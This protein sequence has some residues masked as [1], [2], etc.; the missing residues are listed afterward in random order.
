V[1]LYEQA[2]AIYEANAKS[3]YD[4]SMLGVVEGLAYQYWQSGQQQKAIALY[5]R[6]I[7]IASNAPN[8]NAQSKASTMW[9]IGL[10]YHTGGRDDLAK[11][12][13]DQSVDVFSKEIARLERDKPD[14]LALPAMYGQLGLNYQQMGN[15]PE[16]DKYLR[17][18]NAAELKSP[19]GS[20]A[21][22]A[23][24]AQ[25]VRAEGKPAEALALLQQQ[26]ASYAKRG[27]QYAHVLDT[28]IA[29]ILR[30]MGQLG[31][32]TKLLVAYRDIAAKQYGKRHLM[33]AIA[34][35]QL[36]SMYMLSGD[37]ANASKVLTESLEIS[38]RDLS[39]A[40]KI[41]TESD[42]EIYFSRYGYVLDSAVNFNATFARQL[43]I[44]AKLALE[45]VLRRKGR[46]LD[47]TASSMATIRAKLA[48]EDKQLLDDLASARSQLAKLTVAGPSATGD[49][50]YA[51]A[52]AALEDQISKL[53]IQVGQKSAQYRAV[54]QPITLA[55]VQ[56]VLPKDARLV[57]IINFQPYDA[58]TWTF[59]PNQKKLQRR[60]AAYV[61]A[62]A[63]D[64]TFVDLG[65]AQPID[66]A[67]TAF[68]K[69]VSNPKNTHV[70]D[71]GHALYALTMAKLAGAIGSSTEILIAPDGALNLVPFA[72]L[73]DDK[74]Q[75]LIERDNFTYLTS[76]RDLLRLSVRTK[77]QG[78]G[79][80]FANPAFDASGG[81]TSDGT[82]GARSA[83]LA[84]LMWPQLPGT[85]E[86]ADLV[87]HT[88][89]GFA[90]YR[91]AR[92][93]EGALKAL[94]G[95]RILHL[96]THGFFL[97]DEPPKETGPEGRAMVSPA[98]AAMIGPQPTG[99]ENPLLR[100][101]LALAGANKLKSGDDDGILT[102]LEASGLDLW[103]TQLVVLSACDTGNGK[104]TNGDGVYGLRRALVIAGAES[105]VMSLWQ[106]DD[107]AT[108]DLM[109]GYYERLKAGKPRSSALRD[110]QLAIH[111]QAKYAH[112]FY[113]A[114]FLAAGDNT[115]LN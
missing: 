38:E 91:G 52:V 37:N 102:A 21:W 50:D 76:G 92:A 28:T 26:S 74:G 105:L 89:Q 85:G 73:V 23:T 95:P 31:R 84:S 9:S 106:V 103:G 80:M 108:R 93:T 43:P 11:P 24:L 8:S 40:L 20:G 68:R 83:D 30:E 2:L 87:E 47:A 111:H 48:P 104:I 42:H 39:N 15:L 22:T 41:G 1:R 75:L 35:Q 36:A 90:D 115:P 10:I 7:E 64:P 45:T 63:G 53:E 33:Y 14:D 16:A 94:H 49:D 29:D 81:G 66:D 65:P 58:K 97:P 114:A 12:L 57:E 51:K 109:A 100:S 98:L 5:N 112:P 99:S 60:Y 34:L 44:A 96:A 72:A 110:V 6:T 54:S 71:L 70:T 27:P 25:I 19:Y 107:A 86:E 67:V 18:A 113:W 3:K 56:K 59:L 79:V 32:A 13:F 62:K 17:K 82:R 88:W 4:L 55:A 61:L 101:G 46:V 78:G 69:A 77:A